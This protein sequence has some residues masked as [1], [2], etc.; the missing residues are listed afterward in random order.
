MNLLCRCYYCTK[1]NLSICPLCRPTQYLQL[2][3]GVC[4]PWIPIVLLVLI[5][6]YQ[7]EQRT[8]Y[9]ISRL[10][11]ILSYDA[12]IFK[13][14]HYRY[15]SPLYILFAEIVRYCQPVNS[16]QLLLKKALWNHEILIHNEGNIQIPSQFR[17]LIEY[18]S[19]IISEE[20]CRMLRLLNKNYACKNNEPLMY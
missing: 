15:V 2:I 19:F 20:Q 5:H 17:I 8:L 11:H 7:I 6:H 18:I 14:T 4:L 10:Y 3:Y 9:I 16:Y 13:S 1:A 12:D